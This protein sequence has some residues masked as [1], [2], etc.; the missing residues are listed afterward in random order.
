MAMLASTTTGVRRM[1]AQPLFHTLLND[2][3][4]YLQVQSKNK[5]TE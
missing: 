4:W 3:V 1:R 5:I 2:G